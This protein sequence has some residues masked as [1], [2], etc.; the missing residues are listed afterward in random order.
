MPPY[1]LPYPRLVFEVLADGGSHGPG[2][3]KAVLT[4]AV[5]MGWSWYSRFPSSAFASLPQ[6]SANNLEII[7]GLDHCRVWYVNDATSFAPKL[8]FAGRWGDPN[9]SGDDVIWTAW[10]YLAELALS[11]TGYEVYY[12]SKQIKKIVEDE[13]ERDEASGKFKDYG[14]KKRPDSLLAHVATGTIQNPKA[15]NGTAEMVTDPGFG[16]IDVPRLLLMFDLTEIGRANTTQNTT[17]EITR[18]TSPTFNFWKDRG[19]AITEQKLTYPGVIKDFRHI[20]GVIDI[21]NDLATI[22]QKKG[23]NVEIIATQDTGTYGITD[24]G[25]RQDTFAIKTLAGYPKLTNE[26]AKSTAQVSITKRAVKEAS[27]PTRA[28]QL[29]VRADM[30]QPFDG[31]DIED[32]IGVQISRG[33]TSIDRSY[34]IVGVRGMLDGS[35]YSQVLFV[36]VPIS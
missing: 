13:W 22:G 15:A 32:T 36:T 4:D 33:R 21:R 11:R 30:F 26:T 5:K 24:F 27:Q 10:S 1:I 2:A 31:W 35:G 16:V 12:K 20:P 3:V 28:L 8:V 6:T 34:R 17:V 25:R 9:E 18:S 29:D 7:P 14:A 19:S 23:K